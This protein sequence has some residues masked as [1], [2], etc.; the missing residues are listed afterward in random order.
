MH[1]FGAQPRIHPAITIIDTRVTDFGDSNMTPALPLFSSVVLDVLTAASVS[2]TPFRHVSR[3]S[4]FCRVESSEAFWGKKR[5]KMGVMLCEMSA[6]VSMSA[7]P[8][9]LKEAT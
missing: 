5:V 6:T 3:A 1:I 7:S 2:P 9:V 8:L 4:G